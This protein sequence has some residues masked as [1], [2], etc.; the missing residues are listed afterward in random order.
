MTGDWTKA[1]SGDPA[2]PDLLLA[3]RCLLPARSE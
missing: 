2:P 1:I 3:A